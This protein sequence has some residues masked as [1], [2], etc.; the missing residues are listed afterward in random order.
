VKDNLLTDPIWKNINAVSSGRIY[1]IPD[2]CGN[3]SALGSW[4][5]PGSRWIL[6]LRWMATKIRPDLFSDAGLENTVEE[7]YSGVYGLS[8]EKVNQLINKIS[9][10]FL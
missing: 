9:G 3:A 5:T 8:D 1:A 4:D 2:D 7:F 10:D 6:G